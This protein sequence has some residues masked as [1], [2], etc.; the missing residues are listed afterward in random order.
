MPLTCNHWTVVGRWATQGPMDPLVSYS[1]CSNDSIF[2][3]KYKDWIYYLMVF[4]WVWK[5]VWLCKVHTSNNPT[6]FHTQMKTIKYL[7]KPLLNPCSTLAWYLYNYLASCRAQDHK[8]WFGDQSQI[9]SIWLAE[10]MTS[11]IFSQSDA[12][13]LRLV[14]KPSFMILGT[15]KI[16]RLAAASFYITSELV[17]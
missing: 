5:T 11:C 3:C 10:M 14:S 1:C 9:S 2:V 7:F 6:V 17:H 15:G 12:W 13:D 16:K 4:I 8:T